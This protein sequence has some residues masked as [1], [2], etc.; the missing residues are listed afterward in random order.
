MALLDDVLT[1]LGTLTLTGYTV[2]A[3]HISD[4]SDKRVAVY[5]YMGRASETGFGVSG[6]QYEWPGLQVV[7][8]GD[9]HDYVGPRG[10]IETI[11]KDLPKVQAV[12]I[13]TGGYYHMFRPQQAP[14]FM[15]RDDRHRIYLAVNFIVEKTV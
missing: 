9:P 2:D 6:L 7:V 15:K 11:Y 14:F 10:I 8:R 1:R 3:G 13:G 5:E 4:D 12:Q